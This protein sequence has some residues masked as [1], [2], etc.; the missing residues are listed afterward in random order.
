M[1]EFGLDVPL[2]EDLA[3]I[4]EPQPVPTGE[5]VLTVVQV[6]MGE[7]K[8][9]GAPMYTAIMEIMDVADAQQ[10]KYYMP[11]PIPEDNDKKAKG[12]WR[13]VKKFAQACGLPLQG[14]IMQDAEGCTLS[15]VLKEREFEG[16]L[17]NEIKYLIAPGA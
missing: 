1:S 10:V 15:A 2:E 7:S 17:S 11:L 14:L 3:A 6:T 16:Y 4:P 9:S 5:Y 13:K 12:K 8:S